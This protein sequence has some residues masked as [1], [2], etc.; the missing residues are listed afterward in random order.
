MILPEYELTQTKN[1]FDDLVKEVEKAIENSES[2]C[3]VQAD[4]GNGGN[5]MM[6][7]MATD[8]TLAICIYYLH[9]LY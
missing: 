2:F 1:E 3:I 9:K 5:T 6:K 7:T 8:F 4:R